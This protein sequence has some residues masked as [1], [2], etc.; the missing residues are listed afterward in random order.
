MAL[1]VRPRVRLPDRV[2]PGETVEIKAV[3]SH[4]MENGQRRGPDGRPVPRQIVRRFTCDYAGRRVVDMQLEP[5]IAANPLIG[6][7]L[8]ADR[9]GPLVFRWEDDAGEVQILER[10]LK[11]E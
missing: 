3:I 8:R 1:N 4:P 11:V 10:L 7:W 2:R 9:S 5:S 6:F